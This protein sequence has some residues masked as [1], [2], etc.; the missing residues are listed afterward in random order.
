MGFYPRT[1]IMKPHMSSCLDERGFVLVNKNLQLD[2][3]PHIFAVGDIVPFDVEKLGQNAEAH[4]DVVVKNMASLDR[5]A[6]MKRY[7]PSSKMMLISLGSKKCM[8]INGNHVL[9]EGVTTRMLKNMV[10]KKVMHDFK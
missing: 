2:N 1:T 7:E 4:A 5:R 10:E 8:L 3:N 9:T 6:T